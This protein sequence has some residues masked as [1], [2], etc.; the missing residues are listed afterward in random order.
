MSLM[1]INKYKNFMKN[2]K[3]LS[4]LIEVLTTL[5]FQEN[6]FDCVIIKSKIYHFKFNKAGTSDVNFLTQTIT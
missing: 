6:S 5:T 4:V 3:R 1:F 2:T